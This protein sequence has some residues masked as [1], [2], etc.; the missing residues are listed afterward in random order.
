MKLQF[1]PMKVP[2][3]QQPEALLPKECTIFE[4]NKLAAGTNQHNLQD[5]TTATILKK[6]SSLS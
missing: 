6:L 5:L 3:L 4:A 2:N 1:E